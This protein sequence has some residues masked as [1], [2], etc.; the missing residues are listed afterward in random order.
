MF[1]RGIISSN[2]LSSRQQNTSKNN[3]ISNQSQL[4]FKAWGCGHRNSCQ[5]SYWFIDWVKSS[6]SLEE[7][8]AHLRKIEYPHLRKERETDINYLKRLLGENTPFKDVGK[9][10]LDEGEKYSSSS[11]YGL[12]HP[13]PEEKITPSDRGWTED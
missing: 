6:P 7:I 8:A 13:E 1:V 11:D 5:F 9:N 4:S 3:N 12:Q 10:H 2:C